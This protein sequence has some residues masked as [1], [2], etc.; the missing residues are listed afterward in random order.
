MDNLMLLEGT[1]RAKIFATI[2]AVGERVRKSLW[3]IPGKPVYPPQK[4]P[5]HLMN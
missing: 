3:E 2:G 5:L 1:L 4:R